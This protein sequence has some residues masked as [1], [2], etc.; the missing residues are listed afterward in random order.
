M[1]LFSRASILF[2]TAS[3]EQELRDKKESA[4]Q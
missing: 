2:A 4:Q 1:I 3:S